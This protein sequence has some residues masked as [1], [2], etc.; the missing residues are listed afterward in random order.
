VAG[1]APRTAGTGSV[2]P[3]EKESVSQKLRGPRS[4]RYLL[5]FLGV[6]VIV[7][8]G[9]VLEHV[10]QSIQVF[11]LGV[12]GSVAGGLLGSFFDFPA[13][14]FL[15]NAIFFGALVWAIAWAFGLGG[16]ATF[17]RS[18]LWALI[19]A[20]G[21]QTYH[22]GEHVIQ[23]LQALETGT[24][25]PPGF[26]GFFGNNVI[27]HLVL[28]LVVW[29]PTVYTFYRFG[30]TAVIVDWVRALRSWVAPAAAS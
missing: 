30:G 26:I 14:H 15:Y 3:R 17:D 6:A 5:A 20:G 22:A 27:I 28:N 8:G 4:R 29:L 1:G 2:P 10:T 16:F 25:R 19:I 7:Q 9:H 13:V 11:V 12:P 21:V 23:I 24:N 18:G